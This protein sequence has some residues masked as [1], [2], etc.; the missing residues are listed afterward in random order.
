MNI[1]AKQNKYVTDER[2]E[3]VQRSKGSIFPSTNPFFS[4]PD[5]EQLE[6]EGKDLVRKMNDITIMPFFGI[7]DNLFSSP[8]PKFYER[9]FE[10]FNDEIR[11]ANSNKYSQAG[12]S[13]DRNNQR[14]QQEQQNSYRYPKRSFDG[15]DSNV[16]DA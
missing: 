16:Y 10:T 1:F 4:H 6:E 12:R 3:R 5:F 2:E 14:S 8:F 15:K 7:L 9:E 11:N 13:N